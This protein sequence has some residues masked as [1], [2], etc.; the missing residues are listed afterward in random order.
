LRCEAYD[1][2]QTN[3]PFM[4]FG[5]QKLAHARLARW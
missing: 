1:L 2:A 4:S 3:P 5:P